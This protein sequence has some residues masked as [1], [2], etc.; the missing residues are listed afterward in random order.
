MCL[1]IV[2]AVDQCSSLT[3]FRFLVSGSTKLTTVP[4]GGSSSGW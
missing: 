2:Q 1:R 3:D 4:D